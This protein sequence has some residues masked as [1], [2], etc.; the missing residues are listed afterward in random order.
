MQAATV[1]SRVL[2][3]MSALAGDVERLSE[4]IDIASRPKTH[5]QATGYTRSN[6]YF[7]RTKGARQASLKS[8]SNRRKAAR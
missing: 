6:R 2:G 5:T 3:M 1:T 4:A 8:R 7:K